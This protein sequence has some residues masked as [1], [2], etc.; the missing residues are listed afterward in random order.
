MR[1]LARALVLLEPGQ[2]VSRALDPSIVAL[3]VLPALDGPFTALV[4]A[5][6]DYG[7]LCCEQ[8]AAKMLAACAMYALSDSDR[9]RRDRAESIVLAGVRRE[10]SMWLERRGFKMYPES[11]DTPHEYYGP[12]AA[13]YL[14]NLAF[15]RDGGQLS[16]ALASAVDEGLDMAADASAA[17]GLAWPPSS[18]STCEEGYNVVRFNPDATARERGVDVA[19]RYAASANG[20]TL[21]PAPPNP[22]LGG[23]VAMRAEAAYASAALFRA[24]GAGDRSR[25]LGLANRVV[26][27]LGAEGRLYSTVDSVAAIA[28]VG[29]LRAARVVATGE[30]GGAVEVDGR[31]LATRDAAALEAPIREVGAV[32]GVAAVEVTRVIEEDWGRFLASVPVAVSL[33]SAGHASR[34]FTAGDAVDLRVRIESGYKDGDLLWV[35]LPDALSRIVGGGQ[36]KRFSVDFAGQ[37]EVVVPLA[38]TSVTVDRA[39]GSGPQRFA[40]C[41]RNMFEE[42]RA[43][44]PGMLDV[45]V[46]PSPDASGGASGFGRMFESLRDLFSH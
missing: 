2:R 43:G 30:G 41:V 6:G 9:E 16:P 25:A 44:S 29:E 31:R 33:E 13:R 23:A 27:D 35:C 19:R 40:V 15:L 32:E 12:K 36:V 3:R 14:R 24:G 10:R 4:D 22:W 5:T 20:S 46:L 38:A 26:R 1:R 39:G 7:H 34:R 21:P 8:T 11:R 42:E 17:Y 45:T 37:D 28:L 18:A